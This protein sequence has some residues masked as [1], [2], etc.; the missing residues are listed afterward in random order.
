MVRSV[1][2]NPA[3]ARTYVRATDGWG[4]TTSLPMS[5]S[6]RVRFALMMDHSSFGISV[7]SKY[8]AGVLSWSDRGRWRRRTGTTCPRTYVTGVAGYTGAL[9]IWRFFV[10]CLKSWNNPIKSALLFLAQQTEEAYTAEK[11]NE[12][13]DVFQKRNKLRQ[14]GPGRASQRRKSGKEGKGRARQPQPSKSAEHT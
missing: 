9:E 10:C 5:C 14:A 3:P 1:Q 4:R 6:R 7:A 8:G 12:I 13:P 2:M 11:M